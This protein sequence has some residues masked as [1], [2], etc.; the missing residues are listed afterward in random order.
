MK[1]LLR[2]NKTNA[3][4]LEDLERKEESDNSKKSQTT[5]SNSD[6]TLYHVRKTDAMVQYHVRVA[7]LVHIV[8]D[9]AYNWNGLFF[10]KDRHGV[11]FLASVMQLT[12]SGDIGVHFHSWVSLVFF[13]KKFRERNTTNGLHKAILLHVSSP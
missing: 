12:F 4:L 1:R 9:Y 8:I 10:C 5:H 13:N 6:V 2:Q 3:K 11:F 7:S